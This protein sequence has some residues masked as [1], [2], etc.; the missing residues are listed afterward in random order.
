MYTQLIRIYTRPVAYFE[1][2][3]PWWDTLTHAVLDHHTFINTTIETGDRGHHITTICQNCDIWPLPPAG[4]WITKSNA[5]N[6]T[7]KGVQI[8]ISIVNFTVQ[9]LWRLDSL[10]LGII[11]QHMRTRV[12]V[13]QSKHSVYKEIGLSGLGLCLFKLNFVTSNRKRHFKQILKYTYDDN[14]LF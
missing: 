6:G 5:A 8:V 4:R 9:I 11:L 10:P 3:I 14:S 7:I 13:K 2:H 12:V 1:L